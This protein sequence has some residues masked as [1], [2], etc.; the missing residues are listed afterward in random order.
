MSPYV[1]DDLTDVIEL[2]G[3]MF[4]VFR[5]S[6]TAEHAPNYEEI[7]K[8]PTRKEAEAYLVRK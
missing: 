5:S 6:E 4:V 7:G 1:S 2:R 3:N 8:F